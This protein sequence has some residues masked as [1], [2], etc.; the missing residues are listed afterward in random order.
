M[1]TVITVFLFIVVVGLIGWTATTYIVKT[2]SKEFIK[3]ELKNILDICKM[4][5]V[6]FKS[7][8]GGLIK[9]WSSSDPFEETSLESDVLE[10]VEAVETMGVVPSVEEVEQDTELSQFS[11]ELVEAITEEE[12]KVA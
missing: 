6:S 7:L 2:N 10:V 9:A 5:F 11:P 12:E 4:L 1:T 3:E 8:I